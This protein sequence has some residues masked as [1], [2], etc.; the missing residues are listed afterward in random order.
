[1]LFSLLDLKNDTVLKLISWKHSF[2]R[3]NEEYELT[4]KKKQAL[5]ALFEKG[6]ISQA[7]RDS[8][9]IDIN[10]VLMEIEKQQTAL[11]AKMQGKAE[12]L[13]SQIKTLETLLANYEIQH[14]VGEIDEEI[15]EREI[16]LLSTALESARLELNMITE[17]TNQISPPM[18]E[19]AVEAVLPAEEGNLEAVQN[20]IVED[21]PVAP[22]EVEIATESVEEP[23]VTMDEAEIPKNEVEFEGSISPDMVPTAQETPEETEYTSPANEVA[24]E[25]TESSNPQEDSTEVAYEESKCES[26][27]V[28]TTEDTSAPAEETSVEYTEESSQP[29]EDQEV[30]EDSHESLEEPNQVIESEPQEFEETPQ[31]LE[32][33]PQEFEE[34]P[35]FMADLPEETTPSENF[36]TTPIQ[37][38]EEVAPQEEQETEEIEA[39][40]ATAEDT[41]EQEI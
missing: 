40:T 11:L 10:T 15:Y 39:N 35:Q 27:A 25:T 2:K 30:A 23:V 41:E 14:V 12:E 28:E 17:A 7:T 37:E 16:N 18:E 26:E 5:D 34:T 21:V 22:E 33:E 20:E 3:L 6:R 19:P 24:E 1:M 4:K 29:T 9:D 31:T 8:F 36:E 13:G 38:C 32:S